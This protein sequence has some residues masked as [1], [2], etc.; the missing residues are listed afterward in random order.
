MFY[1]LRVFSFLG[2]TQPNRAR[3]DC[4]SNVVIPESGIIVHEILKKLQLFCQWPDIRRKSTLSEML[5]Q[6]RPRRAT[7]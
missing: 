4:P 7:R 5:G 1:S 2:G 3:V 6:W